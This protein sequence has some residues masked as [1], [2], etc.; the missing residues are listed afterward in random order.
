MGSVIDTGLLLPG[1]RS[2]FFDL[3]NVRDQNAH[4]QRLAMRI[5]S[6][7]DMENHRFL[8]STP[9]M[10]LWGEGRVA[11]GLRS[12][13]YD[14]KNQKYE[15]TIE[16]DRDELDDEQT[17]QIRPRI[18]QMANRATQHKD[19]LIA[20]L[21]IVGGTTHSTG[22]AYNG[23]TAIGLGYDGVSFFNTAHVS[24]L[25]GSQD[26]ALTT[27]ITD[28]TNHIA[29][30]AEW[31]EIQRK[32]FTKLMAYKDD[33]GKPFF[34]NQP[35]AI[36]LY[37]HPANYSNATEAAKALVISQTSN[38]FAGVVNVVSFPWLASYATQIGSGTEAQGYSYM[39]YTGDPIKPFIFQDRMPI[40]FGALELQSESGWRT[41]KYMYGIRA[42]YAMA[43]GAWQFAIRNV[44]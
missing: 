25:S 3:Y 41:E 24:G 12:E 27:T 11:Q 17:N 30:V 32:M 2:E 40:E 39:F 33:Q 20:Q 43:Y 22:L 8:G 42:R 26:N 23:G 5:T 13:R 36:D 7:R 44:M 6:T 21:L 14:V 18:Q 38:V 29:T 10:R 35:G 37:V 15:A 31:K 34:P 16:V 9:P 4:Y 28:T 19:D 1:L